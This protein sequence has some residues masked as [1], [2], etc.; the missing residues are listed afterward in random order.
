MLGP[1]LIGAGNR[2]D[3]TPAHQVERLTGMMG[4][5]GGFE[6]GSPMICRRRRK[7]VLG[8]AYVTRTS[9]QCECGAILRNGALELAEFGQKLAEH[10][11]FGYEKLTF[12]LVI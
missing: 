10:V 6:C 8:S 11:L 4:G 7:P 12:G 3:F 1:S 5:T 2:P 9:P